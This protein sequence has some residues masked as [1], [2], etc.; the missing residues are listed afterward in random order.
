MAYTP[1]T[2]ADS[3]A[4]TSPLSAARLNFM[5]AGIALASRRV[6]AVTNQT[7]WTI[8]ANVTNYAQN[9]GLT[10]AVT[11]NN[12]VGTPDEGQLLWISL[13]GTA[14]RAISYGTAFEDSTVTRPTTT[15]GTNPIDI[16]FKWRTA[17]S[18]WRC[19]SVA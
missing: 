19:M 15:S 12:P 3:P 16:G 13:T 10:G 1:Q 6:S 7:S 14:S 2:W 9:T 17:T 11:I 18:K 4:T 8:D 5:E